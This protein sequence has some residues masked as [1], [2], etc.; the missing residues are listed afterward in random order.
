A[1]KDWGRRYPYC[2]WGGRFREWLF[3]D[4][5]EPYGSF[6]NGAAM[7]VSPAGFLAGNLE[8]AWAMSDR[9]TR[10]THNHPEGMKGAR[11]TVTAIV[12][13]RQGA[14]AEA[15]RN[16]IAQRFDYDMG[17]SVDEIRPSYRFDETCQR[18]VPEALI[19]ALEAEDFEDAVRN[20]VSLGGDADTLAAIAG[21]VAEA[22]FGVPD[23]IAEDVI[24]RLPKGM[25]AMV[26]Q[27]RR[28]LRE[29]K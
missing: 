9:V 20:A 19:C 22:R 14:N 26:N 11:A 21:A 25:L 7:R 17:R 29:L 5:M 23:A 4:D 16:E 28:A 10:V 15:I 27:F 12:L 3:S 8:D 18:T 2:S 24:R 1:L 13:A 6:G